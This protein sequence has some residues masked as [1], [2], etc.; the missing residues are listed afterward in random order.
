[1]QERVRESESKRVNILFNCVILYCVRCR[2][3]HPLIPLLQDFAGAD[4]H[5]LKLFRLSQ[6]IIEYL[7]VSG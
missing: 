3:H 6:L 4:P 5:F 7:M 1:M 2:R